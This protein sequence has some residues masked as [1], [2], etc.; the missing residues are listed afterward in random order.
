LNS[1]IVQ[2]EKEEMKQWEEYKMAW[3]YTH[4]ETEK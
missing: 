4:I 2:L 3:Q 1:L